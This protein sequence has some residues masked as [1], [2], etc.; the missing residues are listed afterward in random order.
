MRIIK[1]RKC[2]TM[3]SSSDTFL[4]QMV[5]SMNECNQKAIKA[6]PSDKVPYIQQ[7]SQIKKMITQVLHLTAQIEQRKIAATCEISEIVHYL[8]SNKLITDLKLDELRAIARKKS[9]IRNN[10]EESDIARIYGVFENTFVNK[11]K[12]DPTANKVV[13]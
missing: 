3:I 8:R 1:C 2:G 7:A 13:K 6:K 11:T 5:L 10:Q 9:E 12:S 4:E